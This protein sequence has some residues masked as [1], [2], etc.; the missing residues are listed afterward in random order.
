LTGID[1]D[2]LLERAAE[3]ASLASRN[4]R[5][6]ELTLARLSSLDASSAPERVALA[7]EAL[8]YRAW[9][10]ADW[11]LARAAIDRAV[12]LVSADSPARIRIVARRAGMG[13]L[14]SRHRQAVRHA[15][16]VLP[17]AEAAGDTAAVARGLMV[18][19]V[20]LVGLGRVDEGLACL[21][22]HLELANS[23][24]EPR[25]LG[26]AYANQPE[27]LIWADRPAD[28]L[29]LALEGIERCER[30]GFEFYRWLIVGN[31]VRALAELGRWDE[32]LDTADDPTDPFADPFTRLPVDLA[33]ADVLVDRGDHEA[34]AELL[35]RS[36]KV[37]DG[38]DDVQ[39]GTELAAIRAKLAAAQ[40][41]WA[42]ARAAVRD[43]LR[44]ALPADNQHR[45][46]RLVAIGLRV[47]ADA[48]DDARVS[49]FPVDVQA[50]GA[51][52]DAL[53]ADGRAYQAALEADGV[54]ALPRTARWL[55]LAAAERTRL[56]GPDP[57]VWSQVADT[58]GIDRHL[59]GYARFR[60]AEALLAARG[61]RQR[62][63][64]TLVE[65]AGVAAELAAR[66]L[67][68]AVRRL[69]ERARLT[70]S[71][72]PEPAA[73]VPDH[74]LTAREAEVLE[75]IGRGLT[76]GEIAAELFI[77]TKTASV[78]V[79]NILRKLGLRSRIQAAALVQRR[80]D[81]S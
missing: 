2:T 65:A 1:H 32:A 48:V 24:L 31:V 61:S 25:A 60:E 70:I 71:D 19:G 22:R 35:D 4:A 42:D 20:G 76:N 11:H 26:V 69:A 41:R 37:L 56:D 53:L 58:A 34:A 52:A 64:A 57:A 15:E 18:R 63:T 6:V 54:V 75:L 66:P 27:T 62:A 81:G 77:S 46:A 38:Q 51:V 33:R 16:E 40:L 45:T 50:A 72:M 12:A 7:N 79:S 21:R 68:E 13:M 39:H 36:G 9:A 80:T 47:E 67:G 3:A 59:A 43:G 10:S 29:S 78:H 73:A 28:A 74:G 14:A 30:Y 55:G 17:L 23:S 49:G 44:V 5:A 8:S